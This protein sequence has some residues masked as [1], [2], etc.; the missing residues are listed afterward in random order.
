MML[1]FVLSDLD[2]HDIKNQGHPK[3]VEMYN[4][5]ASLQIEKTLV[6]RVR[7]RFLNVRVKPHGS[8]AEELHLFSTR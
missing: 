3:M 2:A 7:D 8:S 6:N 1:C 4:L 5:A